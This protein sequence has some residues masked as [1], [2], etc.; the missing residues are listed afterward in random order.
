M[1]EGVH[2]RIQVELYHEAKEANAIVEEQ[3]EAPPGWNTVPA[4]VIDPGMNKERLE[5]NVKRR[6]GRLEDGGN[7]GRKMIS[8][9]INKNIRC[10]S[11]FKHE[12][13]MDSI[14]RV[15]KMD[16]ILR[17]EEKINRKL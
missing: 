8:E 2:E 5:D 12:G 10:Q 9:Q 14:L 1:T 15:G 3:L 17:V 6:K 11:R 4:L 13:K 7:S 16:S